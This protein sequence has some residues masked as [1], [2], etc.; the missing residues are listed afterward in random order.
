MIVISFKFF[1]AYGS[2]TFFSNQAQREEEKCRHS[3]AWMVYK[4]WWWLVCVLTWPCVRASSLRLVVQ[5]ITP[6]LARV[7]QREK[8]N[9]LIWLQNLL[10]DS[11]L[12]KTKQ[13]Y[14]AILEGQCVSC[15]LQ[16]GSVIFFSF[17]QFWIT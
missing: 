5:S 3:W 11:K 6:K 14:E 7:A 13:K 1:S 9:N 16:N 17:L 8:M 12:P 4:L 2:P 10:C 15:Y